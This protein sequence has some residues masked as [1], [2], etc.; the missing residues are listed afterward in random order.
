MPVRFRCQACQRRISASQ[1]K[2][3]SIV[4]CPVCKQPTLVIP[5]GVPAGV[6]G[7]APDSSPSE[8]APATQTVAPAQANGQYDVL[9]GSFEDVA[10]IMALAPPAAPQLL[11]GQSTKGAPQSERPP[12]SPAWVAGEPR[13]AAPPP[14]SRPAPLPRGRISRPQVIE[15]FVLVSR[16]ALFAQ[17]LLFL[18]VAM[19]AFVLGFFAGRI[20]GGA[21]GGTDASQGAAAPPQ[22]GVKGSVV[23]APKPGSLAGDA[24]ALVIVLPGN[25]PAGPRLATAGLRPE[26]AKTELD[27]A[28]VQQFADVGIGVAKANADGEFLVVARPSDDGRVLIVSRSAKRA[29]NEPIVASHLAELGGYFVQPGD[30]IGQFKYSWGRRRIVADARIEQSFGADRQK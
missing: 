11:A 7:A 6:L 27:R 20:R 13:Q 1:R 28:L 15:G 9:G 4:Q 24:N 29:A 17:G 5:E 14:V 18:L 16:R 26:D 22:I 3:G 30:M 21:K 25:P 8:T 19:V 2:I 10:S 23:F 12:T